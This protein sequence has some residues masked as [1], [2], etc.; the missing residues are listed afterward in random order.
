GES[1]ARC[2]R[3]WQTSG[4]AA[5]P[6]A[7][8]AAGPRRP[9]ATSL[10]ARGGDRRRAD[11]ARRRGCARRGR[12]RS[13]RS[14]SA[15]S[16]SP[17]APGAALRAGGPRRDAGA[18]RARAVLGGPGA[19]R[20]AG[21]PRSADWLSSAGAA[22]PPGGRHTRAVREA[23]RPGLA[24][25]DLARSVTVGLGD[26]RVPAALDH[27]DDLPDDAL[28]LSAVAD[29]E[30]D[31]H[32]ELTEP[33]LGQ[34]RADLA[35]GLQAERGLVENALAEALDLAVAELVVEVPAAVAHPVDDHRRH[36]AGVVAQERVG[37]DD[38]VVAL[39][40]LLVHVVHDVFE[41]PLEA[42]L[43]VGWADEFHRGS[44]LKVYPKPAGVS[45]ASPSPAAGAGPPGYAYG[46]LA[47]S[48]PSAR[49]SGAT[50]SSPKAS[51]APAASNS[52]GSGRLPPRASPDR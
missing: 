19:L 20:S 40:G 1:S 38:H 52:R 18:S 12:P 14:A 35:R 23:E 49:A 41:H 30:V 13:C 6:S 46:A 48:S 43:A 36:K 10:R 44:W 25:R 29:V 50:V 27:P 28:G 47:S 33:V 31:L 22:G 2:G 5:A 16:R 9:G 8:A 51:R 42:E 21:R 4:P 7:R 3:G 17:L 39:R 45:K 32:R 26:R 37:A 24:V 34:L 11:R 15:A